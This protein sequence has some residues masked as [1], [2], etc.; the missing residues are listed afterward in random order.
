MATSTL[1]QFL[2]DGITSPTGAGADTSNRRQVETFIS[3]AAIA[4]GD[5]VMLD[6]S[7]TGADRA[8]YIKQCA[9]VA[10]GNPL[11]VGVALNAAAAA[12]EQVRVV[13]SGYVADVDCAG[14][15]ILIGAALSA[16]KTA[17][18]EVNTAAA[19]DTAG[20]FAVALEAKGATTANKV[21]IHIFKRF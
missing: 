9:N 7:K 19:G 16:G 10:T 13:V 17:A 1:V 3:G 5:V 6:T 8:L 21:A 18:G 20:L 11:A 12:G 15:T 2:G 4:A 14:G